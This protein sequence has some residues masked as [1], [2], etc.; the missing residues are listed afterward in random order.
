MSFQYETDTAADVPDFFANLEALLA[1][2]GWT[3][4]SGTGT[5]T[6]VYSSSGEVGTLTKL[7]IR[8]WRDGPNPNRVYF[9][10]QDDGGGT[11]FTTTLNVGYLTAPGAGAVPFVYWITATKDMVIITFKAG[12]YSGCYVGITEPFALA[13]PDET[14]QMVSVGLHTDDGA[15]NRPYARVL[16]RYDGTWDSWVYR[17]DECADEYEP[18]PLDGSH[19]LFGGYVYNQLDRRENYGQLLFCTGRIAAGTGINAEDTITSGYPGVTSDWMVFGSGGLRWAV[20]SSG[21]LPVGI[22][23]GAQWAYTTGVAGDMAALQA[24]LEAFLTARGWVIADWPTPVYTIDRS[25]SS[26]GESGGETIVLRWFWDGPNLSWGAQVYDAIDGAHSTSK[27]MPGNSS[28]EAGYWPIRYYLSGDKDCFVVIVEVA[29]Q[30]RWGWYGCCKSFFPDPAV[31][32]T[33][34]IVGAMNASLRRALRASD[35]GWGSVGLN[36]FVDPGYSGSS[37]SLIDGTSF[38]V[39]PYPLCGDGVFVAHVPWGTL[40]YLYRM[41]SSYWSLGDTVQI[42]L[43]VFM[44]IGGAFAIKIA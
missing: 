44:N 38:V 23:D 9:R 18:H 12:G 11:H 2:A 25:F 35:G 26:V 14:Y 22:P 24:A 10:V 6:I 15:E 1:A 19:A 33:A 21:P 36:E 16:H 43:D 20:A 8:I 4:V 29:T 7:Y 37:P 34:Y 5:T 30:F 40:Q 32:D 3:H 42:G 41:S 28:I 39:W 27:I 13:P 17:V 31:I